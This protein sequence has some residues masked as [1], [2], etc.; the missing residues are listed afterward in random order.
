MGRSVVG[1][2]EELKLGLLLVFTRSKFRA[3]ETKSYVIPSFVITGT[4]GTHQE[5]GQ[6]YMGILL[7]RD[8]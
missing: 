3:I 2:R 5:I 6:I 7:A 4:L 1:S 8:K